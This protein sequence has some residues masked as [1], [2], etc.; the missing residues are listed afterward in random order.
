MLI[1][2]SDFLMAEQI[3]FSPQVTGIYEI[4]HELLNDLRLKILGNQEISEKSQ[5]G[6]ELLP[7]GQS[8][9]QNEIFVSTSKN[10]LKKQKLNFSLSALCRI[11]T[12]VCLK[13]FVND[14][15]FQFLQRYFLQQHTFSYSKKCICGTRKEI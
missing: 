7:S 11:K 8:S 5:N 9:S 2:F 10:L 14:C 3:C 6:I 1:I 13:Y 4:P 12:R 15:S